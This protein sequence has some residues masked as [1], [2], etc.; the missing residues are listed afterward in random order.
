MYVTQHIEMDQ[1][2]QKFKIDFLLFLKRLFFQLNFGTKYFVCLF[3]CLTGLPCGT[4][5]G[6]GGPDSSKSSSQAKSLYK[7][8]GY[9]IRTDKNRL[10]K[11]PS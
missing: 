1:L 6:P 10:K 7:H 8:A 2:S 4:R 9:E 5:L 3:V 11:R